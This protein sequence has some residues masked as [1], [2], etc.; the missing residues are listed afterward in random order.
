MQPT[1]SEN[2]LLKGSLLW[3][4]EGNGQIR[5]YQ[6]TFC[7][8]ISVYQRFRVSNH[9]AEVAHRGGRKSKLLYQ[10][11]TRGYG[12]LLV[13]WLWEEA[14]LSVEEIA[15]FILR[16]TELRYS[17]LPTLERSNDV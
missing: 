4:S 5:S 11:L 6:R 10:F 7:K 8:G 16:I 15:E 17:R 12:V 3:I 14:N 1:E 2:V 9:V 13:S